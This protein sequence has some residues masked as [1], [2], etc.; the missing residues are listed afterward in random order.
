MSW[1]REWFNS[2]LYEKLYSNRNEEE[3]ALL[4]DLIE[5]EAPRTKFPRLLDLGCGRGRHSITFAEKG[6]RVTGIDLSGEAIQKA[7]E[8]ASAKGLSEIE[9]VVGDMREP[10]PQTFDVVVNLFTSFGYFEDDSENRKVLA[11]VAAMLQKGGIFIIDYLNQNLARKDLVPEENGSYDGLQYQIER[12]ITDG[13]IL[14]KIMFSGDDIKGRVQYYE[15]VKLYGY[16]WFHKEF[17]RMGFE[18]FKC[19]GDYYGNKFYEETSPRLLIIAK[20]QD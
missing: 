6:Y 9:F 4:A 19:Y 20:K 7:E 2:P 17:R 10:L 16:D 1:F 14:K 3:A 8:N 12:K 11:A 13:V 5:K 15:R 18:I